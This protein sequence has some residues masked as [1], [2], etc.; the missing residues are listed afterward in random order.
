MKRNNLVSIIALSLLA[1][2]S[3]RAQYHLRQ[4]FIFL[5]M[6]DMKQPEVMIPLA[7]QKFDAQGNL[8]DEA[9][10]EVIRKFLVA[11]VAYI[12]RSQHSA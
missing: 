1:L 12:R 6:H 3:A 10:R 7:S 11:L 2:G 4:V 8:T 5:N 9:T